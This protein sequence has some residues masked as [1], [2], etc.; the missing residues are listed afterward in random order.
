VVSL[1]EKCTYVRYKNKRIEILLGW[2]LKTG[3]GGEVRMEVDSCQIVGCGSWDVGPLL[4]ATHLVR[5]LVKFVA[6]NEKRI[7]R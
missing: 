5:F 2:T 7:S 3:R 6:F 1:G 4:S